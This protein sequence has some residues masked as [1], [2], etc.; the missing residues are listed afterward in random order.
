MILGPV[1]RRPMHV[2]TTSGWLTYFRYVMCPEDQASRD[3][4]EALNQTGVYPMDEFLGL[5]NIPFRATSEMALKIARMSIMSESYDAVARQLEAEY[6]KKP[7]GNGKGGISADTV[8]NITNYVGELVLEAEDRLV[9]EKIEGYKPE[10]IQIGHRRG[11]PK[12][13]PFILYLM[14]DG[15]AYLAREEGEI[16]AGWHE[17]KLGVIFTT[18]TMTTGKDKKGHIRP[19]IGEREYICDLYGVETHRKHLLAAALKNGL[20]QADKMIIIGDGA[21]W[22]RLIKRDLFPFAQQILDLTHLK[23]NVHKFADQQF[24]TSSAKGSAWAD[25]ICEKLEN[26]KW[27]EVINLPEIFQ[28]SEEGGK[29]LEKGKFNLYNY[30][31]SFKDCIDYPTYLEKGYLIGSGAVESGHRTVMQRRIKQPGMRWLPSKANGILILRAK[32]LSG[33]WDS[34]VASVVSKNYRKKQKVRKKKNAPG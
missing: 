10:N 19:K 16:S 33:L 7:F 15:A 27:K 25:D 34:E 9:K 20:E 21:E 13:A 5:D 12:K 18:E 4:L 1:N 29:V 11:R 3:A 17:N 32:L 23:Q 22:I 30:I 8:R 6:G 31:T 24:G 14:T 2:L 28:Y 26:G